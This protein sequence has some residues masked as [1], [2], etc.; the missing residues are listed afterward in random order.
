MAP[1]RE[2]H[3]KTQAFEPIHQRVHCFTVSRRRN[4]NRMKIEMRKSFHAEA[5]S[6]QFMFAWIVQT[7]LPHD[8]D[9]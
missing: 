5:E 4:V 8:P 3:R 2:G 7:V 1:H 9:Q 6:E